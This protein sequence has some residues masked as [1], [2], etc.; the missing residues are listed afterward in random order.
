MPI[1]RR[2]VTQT[3]PRGQ[4]CSVPKQRDNALLLHARLH[5]PDEPR[6]S[7]RWSIIDRDGVCQV[8]SPLLVY[9]GE[10]MER[11][12]RLEAGEPQ[13][14]VADVCAFWDDP[15]RNVERRMRDEK[16]AAHAAAIANT[17][18]SRS[19]VSL[20][21]GLPPARLPEA[22][23]PPSGL[24]SDERQVDLEDAIA[25]AAPVEEAPAAEPT[26]KHPPVLGTEAEFA[27]VGYRSSKDQHHMAY[28]ALAAI[29][30][31]DGVDSAVLKALE[32]AAA[33]ARAAHGKAQKPFFAARSVLEATKDLAPGSLIASVRRAAETLAGMLGRLDGR[34]L[35]TAQHVVRLRAAI[36]TQRP[37]R[38]G[39]VVL[40]EFASSV[41]FTARIGPSPVEKC[42]TADSD[43]YCAAQV[44][45][46]IGRFLK[47]TARHGPG[48][49][50]A[51]RRCRWQRRIPMTPR[52][53]A[54]R[55][56]TSR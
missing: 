5:T 11:I 32:S 38:A 27:K 44:A 20:L 3:P 47:A 39:A 8:G 45:R 12:R 46:S 54:A 13:P 28:S 2:K 23:L 7:C 14:E 1:W 48:G 21:K 25:A 35:P 30:W 53:Q 33:K 6:G 36:D 9:F 41:A 37:G 26:E 56:T 42:S 51:P 43:V 10:G 15:V 19:R 17:A 24:I 22:C 29:Q 49:G 31:E 4:T 50:N 40:A 52:S 18:L 55:T 16:V 34:P